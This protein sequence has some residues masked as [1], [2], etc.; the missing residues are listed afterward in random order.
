[1]RKR[2]E[3]GRTARDQRLH[4]Q[5]VEYIQISK[6]DSYAL[7]QLIGRS[8]WIVAVGLKRE[9]LEKSELKGKIT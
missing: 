8:Y 5:Q 9:K 2:V 4:R 1:V 3:L 7:R 6:K